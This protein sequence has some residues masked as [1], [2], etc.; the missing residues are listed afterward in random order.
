M[1][2]NGLRFWMLADRTHWAI[3]STLHYEDERGSLQ[4]ASQRLL[5]PLP[6]NTDDT[7]AIARLERIP[8]TLDSFGNRAYW[9]GATRRIVATGVQPSAVGL[10]IPAIDE[11][12]TDL[13]MGYDGVLYGAI[14]GQVLLH[15]CRGRW[16]DLRLSIPDFTPWRLAADPNGGVWV[17]DRDAR[18]LGRVQGLPF[19]D[20][21]FRDYAAGTARPCQENPTPPQLTRLPAIFPS[22]ERPVAIACSPS[23]RLALLTWVTGA[24]ARIRYLDGERWS[25]PTTL[26]GSRFP[27]SLTWVRGDRLAVLL[28]H[29]ADQAPVYAA[30]LPQSDPLPPLGDL[31]PLRDPTGDPFLHGVTLP[32]HYAI[33]EGSTPLYHLSLPAYA[34]A[35]QAENAIAMDSESDRTVWHRL[36]L[37]AS[38]PPQCGLRIW[39]AA[40]RDDTAPTDADQWYEH[41]VGEC[42]QGRSDR[43]IPCGAWVSDPSEIP[44]HPGLLNC[45]PERD[46]TGLFTVL[47]QRSTCPVRTL[48]GRF[49]HVRVQLLGNGHTTPELAALRAYASRFSYVENYLP[50]FYHE[51]LFGKDADAIIPA[52][53]PP[54]STPAD[55]L[56]RFLNTFESILTPLEDR[57]AQ[58]YLLTEPR[59]VPDDSLEW[60]G[61]WIGVT[62]D[63]AYPSDRRRL[64][65]RHAPQLYRQRGTLDGLKLALDLATNG[66][67]TG[68][69][70]LVLEDF[71]L[72]RTFATI[73]GADLADEDDPLLAGL[74]A[75]GNSFVGDT[76]ILGDEARQ[77]FLALYNAEVTQGDATATEVVRN[78][79]DRLAYRVTVFVHQDVDPQDLSLIRRVVELETPAHIL[80]RVVQASYPLLVGIASLV[81]VDTYLGRK[82]QPKPVRVEDSAIGGGDRLQTLPS[83]DPRLEGQWLDRQRPTAAIVPPPP[84]PLATSFVLDASPSRAS[85]EGRIARYTWT[86][87]GE[88]ETPS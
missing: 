20:R 56:E 38:I 1:D 85:P 23:G 27:Y 52:D 69:E 70:L 15:D 29:L 24:D 48:R 39:L 58:S 28:T 40:S 65:L 84:I 77:E 45:P 2:A 3:D 50:T 86:L 9:D 63:S 83:L 78:L 31:Y 19:P 55:F 79:F 68:G 47:I 62:F 6:N 14:A 22:A 4:L 41:R 11:T 18:Q 67:V 16:E 51:S 59:T 64:L 87:L 73:L 81:G 42:F 35:G 7:E 49:L 71:R 74:V 30:V 75:S 8:Q 13:A 46:R 17:L 44:F 5:P 33:A 25:A 60:L 57:I 12:P 88:E 34:R 21:A 43:A 66:A 76:L 53:Q 32:P 10:V 82:P 61:S 72:R 36:Y 26:Q 37:E 54:V 80:S